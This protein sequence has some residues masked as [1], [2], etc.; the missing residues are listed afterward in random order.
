MEFQELVVFFLEFD[1]V[2]APEKRELGSP[3]QPSSM[4][5]RR[6]GVYNISV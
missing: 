5:E 6:R 3:E 2:D 1:G 4:G